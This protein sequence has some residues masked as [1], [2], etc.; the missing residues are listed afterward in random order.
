MKYQPLRAPLAAALAAAALFAVCGASAKEPSSIAAVSIEDTNAADDSTS[1][2]SFG[3]RHFERMQRFQRC[4]Q[5][6]RRLRLAEKASLQQ[7]KNLS[8]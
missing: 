7:A 6:A 3:P 5:K 1:C 2:R 4:V 8:K